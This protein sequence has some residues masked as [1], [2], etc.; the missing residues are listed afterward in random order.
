[1][2]TATKDFK[3]YAVGDV[4]KGQEVP[5]NKCWLD[6]G[7]IVESKPEQKK[8]IETKPQPENKIQTKKKGKK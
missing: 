8:E 4:K 2:Y 6:A 7:M 5:F 1:M 3:A